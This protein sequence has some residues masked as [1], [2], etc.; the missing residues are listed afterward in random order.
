MFCHHAA[1]KNLV[2]NRALSLDVLPPACA[3]A[4]ADAPF[5]VSPSALLRTR[6][7]RFLMA[8]CCGLAM[9]SG[10]YSLAA[11]AGLPDW[12][13]RALSL[14]VA[15]VLTWQLNRAFTFGASAARPPV[16]FLRYAGVAL[17]AQGINYASFLVL[18]HA[19]PELA[20]LLA[21]FASAVLATGFS[22][23]GQSMITFARRS[24]RA[25]ETANP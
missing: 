7:A 5:A 4:P 17:A 15:T 24:P 19:F 18:R 8:G 2:G 10:V 14:A 13:A 1:A 20:P 11:H 6:F 3:A 25:F 22:F 16:E 9:D 23:T 12:Q 21:L